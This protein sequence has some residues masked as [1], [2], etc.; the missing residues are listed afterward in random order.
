MAEKKVS[1]YR[2]L[3][4]W[5]TARQL[6]IVVHEMTLERLPKDLVGQQIF[7]EEL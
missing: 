6:I 1:S 4:I 2:D 3:E 7:D 5:K